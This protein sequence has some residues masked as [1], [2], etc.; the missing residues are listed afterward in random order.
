MRGRLE[1]RLTDLGEMA[2]KNIAR[3]VRVY[4]VAPAP[5]A[6]TTRRLPPRR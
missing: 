3:P 1:A 6:R 5:A 4:A 2:L